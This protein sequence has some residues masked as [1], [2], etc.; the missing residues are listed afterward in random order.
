[1]TV[2]Q[3][4]PQTIA[5]A[6]PSTAEQATTSATTMVAHRSIVRLVWMLSSTLITCS[7]RLTVTD[8]LGSRRIYVTRV[9]LFL[10]PLCPTN[11]QSI[12]YYY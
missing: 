9:A 3:E 4:D 10:L 11:S 7:Q 2:L 5:E 1:M 12:Q 6:E 8:S